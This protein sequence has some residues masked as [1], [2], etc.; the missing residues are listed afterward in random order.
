MQYMLDTN[1]CIYIIKNNPAPFLKK[2][3]KFSPNDIGISSITFAELLYGVEK[4]QHSEKNRE[5]LELFVSPLEIFPFNDEA[6][7]HYGILRTTLEKKGTPIGSLDLLIAAH[8]ESLKLTLVTNNTKE[9][10]R[11]PNLLVENWTKE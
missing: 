10:S 3:K 2:F 4:S 6:A 5:A 11:V 8:A 7:F 1:I 9:F